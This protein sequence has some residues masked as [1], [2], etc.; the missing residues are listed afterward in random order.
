MTRPSSATD[1]Y[2]QLQKETMLQ[3]DAISNDIDAGRLTVEEGTKRADA[4]VK[5]VEKKSA[6]LVQGRVR[7]AQQMRVRSRLLVGV[8]IV[9]I[10]YM[11]FKLAGLFADSAP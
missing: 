9:A 7:Q 6:P 11:A 10:A 3:L 8:V 1:Q 5:E 2:N 4:L